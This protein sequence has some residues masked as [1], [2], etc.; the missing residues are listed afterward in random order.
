M[1]NQSDEFKEQHD[2]LLNELKQIGEF[3]RGNINVVYRKCGKPRCVCNREGHKGHGPMITLT[4]HEG[5]KTRTRS[6]SSPAAEEIV[7]EQIENHKGFVAWSR[8]WREL[9]E[10][11]S[12]A[13]LDQVLRGGEDDNTLREKKRLRRSLRKSGGKSRA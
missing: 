3:R 6:L 4:F 10:K 5:G 12:D 8:K 11:M 2:K 7:K 9:N 13:H 1:S